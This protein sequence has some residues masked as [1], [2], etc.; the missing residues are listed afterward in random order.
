MK[1]IEFIATDK[2]ISEILQ[3][4]R[5]SKNFIPDWYKSSGTYITEEKIPIHYDGKNNHTFKKCVPFLDSMISGY[6]F[7]SQSDIYALDQNLHNGTRLSWA[8][9][10]F[11]QVDNNHSVGQLQN[12]PIMSNFNEL[13]KWKFWWQ[14]KTPPGYSCLFLHPLNRNDLPFITISGIVDTD[15]YNA[16]IEFPF[17]LKNDFYGKISKGTPLVQIIPFKRDS[18]SSSSDKFNEDIYKN[19]SKN[20]SI[21]GDMYKKIFWQRKVFK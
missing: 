7:E 13:F 8:N 1:K 10:P 14:I 3:A 5:P 15:V 20:F 16:P 21:I 9:F 17:F 12:Y 11:A 19:I 6:T 18:W 4:P 2:N